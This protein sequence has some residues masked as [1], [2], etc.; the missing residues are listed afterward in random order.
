[1]ESGKDRTESVINIDRVKKRTGRTES[2]DEQRNNEKVK[3]RT[4]SGM[5]REIM[6]K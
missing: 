2:G 1:M 3:E 4:E 5:N 6:K